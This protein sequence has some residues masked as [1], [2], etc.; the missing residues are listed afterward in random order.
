MKYCLSVVIILLITVTFSYAA[1]PDKSFMQSKM[2]CGL[3]YTNLSE[4]VSIGLPKGSWEKV[5]NKA[6]IYKFTITDR[7]TGASLIF[8]ILFTKDKDISVSR[9]AVNGEEVRDVY[10]YDFASKVCKGLPTVKKMLPK[11]ELAYET[12]QKEDVR[13]QI[14]ADNERFYFKRLVGT[15][16]MRDRYETY[17]SPS[18]NNPECNKYVIIKYIHDDIADV[19]FISKYNHSEVCKIHDVNS[20]VVQS[21]DQFRIYNNDTKCKIRINAST[22]PIEWG[23]EGRL[24]YP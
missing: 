14:V 20:K 23:D 11:L 16:E 21:K 17:A 8:K 10:A 12:K 22:P 3:A 1:H 24:A 5:S 19:E 6:W 7:L 13:K 2:E 18:I 4:F 9:V 15:Y